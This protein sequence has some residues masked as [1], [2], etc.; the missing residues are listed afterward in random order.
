LIGWGGTNWGAEEESGFE[1]MA[2]VVTDTGKVVKTE[3]LG[4]VIA[5]TALSA[6]VGV[7]GACV[8]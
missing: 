4:G 2:G 1:I 5:E 7:V 3:E 6:P 8:G